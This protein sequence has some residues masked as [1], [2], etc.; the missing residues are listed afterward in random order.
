MRTLRLALSAVLLLASAACQRESTPPERTGSLDVAVTREAGRIRLANNTDRPL[1]YF[2]IESNTAMLALWAACADPGPGCLRLP[3]GG[4]VV[5][6]HS[7]I[8]GYEP[9]VRSAIVHWWRVVPDGEG[10]YRVADMS[11][12]VVAL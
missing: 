7:E 9:G 6:P 8:A 1:A 5:V 10:R 11:S 4:S 3:A 2:A 12:T